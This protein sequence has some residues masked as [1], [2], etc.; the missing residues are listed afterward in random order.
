M[1]IWTFIIQEE[2]QYYYSKDRQ[3]LLSPDSRKSSTRAVYALNKY[4]LGTYYLLVLDKHMQSTK[5]NIVSDF[6]IKR[7]SYT[8]NV[9]E[10]DKFNTA[11]T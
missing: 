4:Q 2:C 8:Q 10:T 5:L 3:G 6:I 7:E 11:P 1:H 9:T